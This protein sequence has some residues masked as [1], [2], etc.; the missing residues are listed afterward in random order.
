MK[1]RDYFYSAEI[2]GIPTDPDIYEEP[3]S[4]PLQSASNGTKRCAQGKVGNKPPAKRRYYL[5]KRLARGSK[6]AAALRSTKVAGLK[7]DEGRGKNR[8][9]VAKEGEAAKL[10]FLATTGLV[11]MSSTITTCPGPAASTVAKS[12]DFTQLRAP[13]WCP[14]RPQAP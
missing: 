11:P 13:P 12:K 4:P 6:Q 7:Q 10:S 3:P 9:K 8:S 2:F 14:D 5:Q 1:R